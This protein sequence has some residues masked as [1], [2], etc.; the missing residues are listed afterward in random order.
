MDFDET[1]APLARPDS[2]RLVMA[3]AV[4]KGLEVHQLDFVSAYLN[5]EIEEELYLEIP[6]LL[7]SILSEKKLKSFPNGKVFK[8][9][10]VVR[11]K[12]IRTSMVRK[13]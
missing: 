2:I 5:G 7:S 3:L 6:D 12:T 9:K 10:K 4:E 8:L 11:I 1:F 13:A